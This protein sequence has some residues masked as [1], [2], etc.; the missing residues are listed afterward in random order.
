MKVILLQ[1]V[2]K[3]GQ[4]YDVKNVSDGHALNFLI[5]QGLAEPASPATLKRLEMKRSKDEG[6]RKAQ[7][8]M[9]LKNIGALEGVKVVMIEQANDKGHLFAGIKAEELAQAIMDQTKLDVRAENIM[10]DKPIKETGEH[11]VEVKVG[12]MKAKISVI[13]NAK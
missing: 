8:E 4:K 2:P 6:D 3:V 12:D 1:H 13:V 7:T 9:L 10:L 5:P 11:M